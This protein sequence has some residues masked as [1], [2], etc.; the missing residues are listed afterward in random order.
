MN[1]SLPGSSVQGG[2]PDK[3]TG[4]GFHVLLHGIFP[5][6]GSKSG[7]PNCRQI[8]YQ[9]NQQGRPRI[10]EWVA[11]PFSRGSSQFRNWTRVNS[12]N[13]LHCRQILCQ[14]SHQ[15]SLISFSRGSSWP[16]D[17]SASFTLGGEFFTTQ[18]PRKPIIKDFSF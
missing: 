3:N 5:T 17:Q 9:L 1:C 4:V 18:P 12:F 8:I 14:L 16:W 15:G 7:L 6:Y 11:Y 2:S 10:L 13:C